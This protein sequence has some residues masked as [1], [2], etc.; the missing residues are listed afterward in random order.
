[1][2]RTYLRKRLRDDWPLLY[3]GAGLVGLS[4]M[5]EDKHWASDIVLG[6]A[7]GIVSG[8]KTVRFNHA[9]PNNRLD[10]LFL[11]DDA[12]QLRIAPGPDGTLSF[13]ALRR[14]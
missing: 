9:R 12:L 8:I 2:V 11:G 13:G 6:A 14:W 3:G 1:M 4:R 10:R 5:Y 7:I